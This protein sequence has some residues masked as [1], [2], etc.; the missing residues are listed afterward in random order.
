MIMGKKH[1]FSI[2]SLNVR[3]LHN[4][5]KRRGVMDW[6]RSQ[7]FD[8]IMLQECYST[9]QV[10]DQWSKD[11]GGT[12][13]FSHGTNHSKGVMVL[14]MPG[15]DLDILCKIIDE[16]GR[17]IILKT[18]IQGKS[19]VLVN[20]YAPNT[21]RDKQT[22][23]K[24]LGDKIAELDISVNDEI[25]I[26]G[27]WNSI[28][29]IKLDR[30]G[31]DSRTNTITDSFTE[32][33]GQ[34]DLIDI[35]RCRNENVKRFTYRRKTPLLFSRLDY[36]M[37]SNNMQDFVTTVD[38]L[39]NI[40]SD[41]SAISMH[42]K[43]IATEKR[44][45][46][47]WKF[48]SSL[49][50]DDEYREQ[51]SN[52]IEEC[53][54][55]Y[56]DICDKR[57]VWEL[58]KYEI[59]KFTMSYSSKKKMDK[60]YA[61]DKNLREL[62]LLEM[63]LEINSSEELQLKVDKLRNDIEIFERERAKG[64]IL[65]SKVKWFEEGEKSTKFFFDLEKYNYIKKQIRK[66]KLE[67]GKIVTDDHKIR[68]E[69]EQFYRNLYQSKLTKKDDH[70]RFP[71][72]DIP[73]I[74]E[75]NKDMCDADITMEECQEALETF[76]SNKSPGNDGLT[77]EFYKKFWS[78]ISPSLLASYSSAFE[79][80]EMTVSQRQAII[81]LLEKPGKDRENVKN[82][83]PISLLNMDYKIMT[84]VMSLRLQK[85]LTELINPNQSGF[86]RNRYMGESIRSIL[87]YTI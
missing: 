67:D 58:L 20:V 38:I 72:D 81:T 12:C 76:E 71:V 6:A 85:C 34:Y 68:Q 50:E 33:L 5:V 57:V 17:Y 43:H 60:R 21:M 14:G 73:R 56:E 19:Y 42:V 65:R 79:C 62:K 59:R 46:S 54:G 64:A 77:V 29:D 1:D 49:I 84:K 16:S 8:I 22:F 52:V 2:G 10:E 53:K 7:C 78:I 45:N 86:I 28:Q 55:Q 87:Y 13:L 3:G 24:T 80:G 25:I 11:W 51:I 4:N 23:F 74:S 63:E 18:V 30:K 40:W 36:F 66:L 32:L 48:N 9:C 31:G 26:A 41:H 37:I 44:G 39:P 82:W 69:L 83:R 27:D 35:W 47:Y 61:E 15:L 70:G 75:N